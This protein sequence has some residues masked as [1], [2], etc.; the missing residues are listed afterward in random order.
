[1]HKLLVR[2]FACL[3]ALVL[4]FPTLAVQAS[5]T[6][7]KLSRVTTSKLPISKQI[8]QTQTLALSF[9]CTTVSE[10]PQ[11]ECEALVALYNST[12]GDG[13][14]SNTNWLTSTTINTWY[15]VSVF[16]GHVTSLYLYNNNLTGSIPA[17]LGNLLNLTKLYLGF[18]RLAGNIPLDLGKLTNLQELDLAYNQL[19]GNLPTFFSNLVNLRTLDLRDN[20]L[21][22]NVPES[23]KDLTNLCDRNDAAQYCYDGTGLNLSYNYLNLDGHSSELLAYLD[24][25]DPEWATNQV[26]PFTGCASISGIPESECEALVAIYNALDGA[27][28][29][30][31]RN[32]FENDRPKT[33]YR[34]DTYNGHVMSLYLSNNNLKGNLPLELLSFTGP[35]FLDLSHNQLTGNIPVELGTLYNLYDLELGYNQ[36]TGSIPPELAKL[37]NLQSLGLSNNQLSGSIPWQLADLPNLFGLSLSFN[38]LTGSIP[39]QLGYLGNLSFLYLDNNELTGSIPAELGNLVNLNRLNLSNNSF[40]GNVPDTF[41]NLVNLCVPSKDN[42]YCSGGYDV[43]LGYNHLNVPAPEPLASFLAIRDPDWY[44]TQTK[45]QIFLPLIRR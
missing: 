34:V 35:L 22:G 16:G 39:R 2:L 17:E 15:G 7:T 1:M 9:D 14:F 13:W 33:W 5:P 42:Y 41:V 29:T 45:I 38:Q 12:N 6:D 28:W 44:L 19:S 23:F 18:N 30:D 20:N 8:V 36:L 26:H 32:W 10:V 24:L 3:T 31:R 4:L 40:Y 25:K 21:T 37:P 43:D 27:N 11:P